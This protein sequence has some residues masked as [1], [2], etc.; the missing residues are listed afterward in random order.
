MAWWE[1]IEREGYQVPLLLLV[2]TLGAMLGIGTAIC[3][4]WLELSDAMANFAGGVAGAALGAAGG[5]MTAIVVL[6]SQRRNALEPPLNEMRFRIAALTYHIKLLDA[7][8]DGKIR[9][10]NEIVYTEIREII[11]EA[12]GVLN[13]LTPIAELPIAVNVTV[14]N[15]RVAA[16]N[17]LGEM[18]TSFRRAEP[19]EN[20]D[21]PTV[22]NHIHRAQESAEELKQQM[23]GV[24]LELQ[25]SG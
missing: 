13:T 6:R 15:F 24:D 3:L 5:A 21:E 1:R 9:G 8:I 18:R 12:I 22:F 11:D 17:I 10:L 25:R 20:Q 19:F 23:R 2:L 4:K 16:T 7:A 14:R